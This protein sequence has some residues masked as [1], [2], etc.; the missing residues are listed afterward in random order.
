M[1]FSDYQLAAAKTAIYPRRYAIEYLSL[2]LAG[3]TG[4]VA[5]KIAKT[6]RDRQGDFTPEI[7]EAISGELGDTL[8]MISQL[9]TELGIPLEDI[10]AG[11]LAKLQDRQ[12]RNVLGGSGDKR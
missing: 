8:W 11:N 10:A 4:E 1:N 7:I 9:A 5:S 12:A 3:E 2:A 6:F